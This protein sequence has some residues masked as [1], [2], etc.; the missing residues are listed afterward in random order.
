MGNLKKELTKM[1][2]SDNVVR[3]RMLE[4]VKLECKR[5]TEEQTI[6]LIKDIV[7]HPE[8]Y[9]NHSNDRWSALAE[10]LL[11]KEEKME[12]Y[13][14]VDQP[15]SYANFA[16]GYTDLLAIRQMEPAMRL[17]VTL[18][19]ALMPDAHAGYGL[20]V[21]G[22]L[23]T[24]GVVLPYAVGLDIGCR[25]SLTILD[26]SADLID[27]H[28]ERMVQALYD[29]TAFGMDGVLPFKVYHSVFDKE[30]FRTI[31]LLKKLRDK[32]IRQLG[33]SGGGNHFVDIC[34]VQLPADNP[35]GLQDGSYPAILS[36]SGS[37]GFGAAIAEH[38][39]QI[40]KEQ[41]RLP[42]EA[43]PFAWLDLSSEAGEQYWRSMEIAGEYA[44]ACHELIHRYVAQGMRFK[45]LV[46]ISHHHN[47]AWREKLSDGREA[48]V[49]RKG[50][51]PAHQGELGIIPGSMT[52]AGYIVCGKGCVEA[53]CSANHGAGRAISRQEARNSI[54]RHAMRKQLAEAGV[55]LLGGTTEEAPGAY[56]SMRE[57][58]ADAAPLVEIVGT[59][60]PRIVRM[61]KE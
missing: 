9:K 34:A 7:S 53:L 47:F 25:M 17:P 26:G 54:S 44:A 14:L 20:P 24:D 39:T 45:P 57:V 27:K 1:G 42:R 32:A 29:N 13:D 19:G 50:A 3:S 55:E 30:E 28:K 10:L 48:V 22:V 15:L 36:H 6:Q 11:P 41:C 52:D 12:H 43:G 4:F 31:P 58:M 37:R 56:K 5:L 8:I 61:N 21:G 59:I 40:A 33:S 60:T 38:F 18:A 23:A 35:L 2:V 46:N 16:N 51:T 49:H